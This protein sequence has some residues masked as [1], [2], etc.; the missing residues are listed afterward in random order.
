MN[1]LILKL[2]SVGVRP[3]DDANTVHQ[4]TFLVS[5]AQRDGTQP[6]EL[7][8]GVHTGELVAGVIGTKKFAYDIWGDAVNVA[9]R[10]ELN[11]EPGKINIS[12]STYQHLGT[13]FSCTHRGKLAVKH[14]GEIDMYFVD[15]T[16]GSK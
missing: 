13:R 9:S 16:A 3:E 11:G 12:G 14:R 15:G 10:L 6:W 8:I 5:E 4:K 7:R 2:T 1:S